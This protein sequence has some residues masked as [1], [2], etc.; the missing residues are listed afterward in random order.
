M[1]LKLR[2]E[3]DFKIIV[4]S[5]CFGLLAGLIDS[6]ADYSFYEGR[7]LELVLLR[8]PAHEIYTRLLLLLCV[9]I[10]G[11]S[12]SRIKKQH[13][14]AE[15]AVRFHQEQQSSHLDIIGGILLALDREGHI[16]LINKEGL[17]ILG[18]SQ[19]EA[20]GKNWFDHCLPTDNR[21]ELRTLYKQVMEGNALP[22]DR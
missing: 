6:I 2:D 16:T 21:E 11:L 4:L 14:N 20:M 17:Q 3:F 5:I 13:Q 9:L 1:R 12:A 10:F 18:H 19:E 8:P 15:K 22:V 7:F